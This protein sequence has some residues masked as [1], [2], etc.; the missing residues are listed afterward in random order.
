MGVRCQ[1]VQGRTP[2]LALPLDGGGN[3][4]LRHACKVNPLH[5]H[6][7]V[8]THVLHAI[9]SLRRGVSAMR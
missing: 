7:Y 8:L 1:V 4:H 3:L 2:A 9:Q 5:S 6:A